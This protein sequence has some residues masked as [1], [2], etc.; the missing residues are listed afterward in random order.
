MIETKRHAF[1]FKSNLK[2]GYTAFSEIL[3]FEQMSILFKLSIFK[4]RFQHDKI[5]WFLFPS[6]SDGM[7][8]V[9]YILFLIS[10]ILRKVLGKKMQ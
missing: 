10:D 1:K 7:L 2:C 8:F 3:N 6:F 5:W 9:V 4:K